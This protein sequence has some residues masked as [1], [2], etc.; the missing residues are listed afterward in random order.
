MELHL[1]AEVRRPYEALAEVLR[2][3]PER[4]LPQA[5]RTGEALVFEVGVGSGRRSVRRRVAV[6]LSNVM[7]FGY[8]VAV[9]IAWRAAHR[10]DLYPTLEGVLRLERTE[11]AGRSR[12]RF[13]ATYQPPAGRVGMALDQALMHRVA[14]ASLRDF[15]G[16][17]TERLEEAEEASGAPAVTGGRTD[18]EGGQA[19]SPAER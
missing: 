17:C 19:V 12:L 1:E 13:D 11:H 8:G 14:E 10:P 5:E 16:R 15:L 6:T 9:R 3:G 18:A 7:P 2:D 4:W